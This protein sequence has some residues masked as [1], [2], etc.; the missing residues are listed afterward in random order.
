M[1]ACVVHWPKLMNN[2]PHGVVQIGREQNTTGQA[3]LKDQG[4]LT[5]GCCAACRRGAVPLRAH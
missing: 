3:R 1:S 4:Y 2:W 5:V